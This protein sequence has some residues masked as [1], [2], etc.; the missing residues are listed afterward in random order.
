MKCKV[1]SIDAWRDA[2]GWFWNAW[3]STNGEIEID[4]KETNRSILRKMREGGWLTEFSKGKVTIE[5]DQY[6]LVVLNKSTQ[7]P[8]FAIEY[9]SNFT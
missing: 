7:Q 6:N 9:G 3:Y 1:L 2:D 4:E 5:D 8:L